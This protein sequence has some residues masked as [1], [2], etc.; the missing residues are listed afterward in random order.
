MLGQNFGLP[1]VLFLGPLFTKPDAKACNRQKNP[2]D[3]VEFKFE[4][5]AKYCSALDWA[6]V[7]FVDKTYRLPYEINPTRRE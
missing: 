1:Y 5:D 7:L 4:T 2:L 3:F 6:K